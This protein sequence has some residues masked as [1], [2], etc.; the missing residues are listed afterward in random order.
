[1]LDSN[2]PTNSIVILWSISNLLIRDYRLIDNNPVPIT[3]I[4]VIKI[5]TI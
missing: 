5:I 4:Q 3:E 1:M 2:I